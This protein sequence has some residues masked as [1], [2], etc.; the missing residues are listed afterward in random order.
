MIEMKLAV[1]T[2]LLFISSLGMPLI[3]TAQSKPD[4]RSELKLGYVKNG[5]I[6]CGCSF[7]LNADDLRNRRYIFS[8]ELDEP[9]YIN[10]NGKNL[11]LEPVDFSEATDEE[12]VGQ[13]SWKIYKAGDLKVR[14]DKVVTKIC[15]PND[16]A[17]EVTYYNA[18]MTITQKTQEVTVKLAGLCGC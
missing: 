13:R 9:A 17:C 11:K 16:E 18:T 6:G 7:S 8:E 2:I 4:T 10:V 14:L 5:E 15:D 12:K 1:V 3:S